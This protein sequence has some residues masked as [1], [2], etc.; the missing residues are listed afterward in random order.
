MDGQAKRVEVYLQPG[1]IGAGDAN[2]VFK[3]LL[4]SCVSI[5][6][7]HPTRKIGAMS[8][9]LLPT[10][11]GASS[12]RLDGRYADEAISLMWRHMLRLGAVPTECQAKIFG[13]GRMFSSEA[14][15]GAIA[16]GR[17]N[18][19][20]ARELL[21]ARG[22]QVVAEDL[23]GYGHRKLVFDVSNGDVWSRQVQPDDPD[24]QGIR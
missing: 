15:P 4:G 9:F 13:G 24:L 20:E 23:F 6:L 18:G 7:W 10:R 21:R 1:E 8:H 3:T 19:D 5:T 17:R 12:G 22:I 14:Q 2:H 11:G 16:V